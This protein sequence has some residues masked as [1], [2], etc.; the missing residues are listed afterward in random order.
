MLVKEVMTTEVVT[1]SP[2]CKL[3]QVLWVMN[4]KKVYHLPVVEDGRVVGMVVQHDIERALRSPQLVM[5]SPVEWVM[6]R[7]PIT[8]SADTPIAQAGQLMVDMKISCLPVVEA[9]ILVGMLGTSDMLK[10]LIKIL[11]DPT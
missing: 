2:R 10:I 6:T 1:I 11:E 8:V 7:N 4:D 9:G 3:E 5:K